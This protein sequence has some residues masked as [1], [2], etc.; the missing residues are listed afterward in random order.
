MRQ[1]KTVAPDVDLYERASVMVGGA[2]RH[3]AVAPSEPRATSSSVHSWSSAYSSRYTA[4][5]P[6]RIWRLIF[7]RTGADATDD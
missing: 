7:L 2:E 4:N 6:Y 3:I 1:G 5:C